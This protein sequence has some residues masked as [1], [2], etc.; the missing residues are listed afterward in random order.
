MLQLVLGLLTAQIRLAPAARKHRARRLGVEVLEGR[1]LLSAGQLDVA[2]DQTGMELTQLSFGSDQVHALAIEPNSQIVAV[3]QTGITQSMFALVRFNLDGTLDQSFGSGGKV[4]T[5]VEPGQ[6][7]YAQA[8]V[9][10]T[11]G[12]IV[13]AGF[14]GPAGNQQFALVRYNPDGSLDQ[15]FGTGG[16]V[17]TSFVSGGNAVAH[18]MALQPDGSLVVAG[19]FEPDPTQAASSFA[20]ARYTTSGSL[21]TSFGTGGL[22]TTSFGQYDAAA[23]TV[24]VQPDGS[25]VA[26]GHTSTSS[27]F[28]NF[29]L[30]RYHADGSLDP[31]FGTGGLVMTTFGQLDDA[32]GLVLQSDGK[33]VAAGSYQNGTK[34]DVALARYNPDGSLDPSFGS[35]GQVT[36][37]LGGMNQSA[38]AVVVQ[39]DGRLVAAGVYAPLGPSQFFLAR[40]N[41]DGSLDTTF[42]QAGLVLTNLSPSANSGANALALLSDGTLVA[43]GDGNNEF[44]LARYLDLQ[45]SQLSLS[46]P[47]AIFI[48]RAYQETLGR[49]V[50]ASGLASW[51]AALATGAT[52][53]QVVLGITASLEYRTRVVDGLY[54]SLL[55]RPADPFGETTFVT[56]L[57]AG[58]TVEQV[59]AAILGSPEYYRRAGSADAAFLTSLYHAVLSRDVDAS[60]SA[61]WMSALSNGMDRA[62][63][64]EQ[65]LTSREAE[66]DLVL[67]DY[68]HFLGRSADAAGLASWVGQLASGAPDELIQA[69]FLGSSEFYHRL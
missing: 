11:D 20:L 14:A 19:S 44:A 23:N 42:G 60:G 10:Q 67:P 56:A 31:S 49:P 68:E 58:L 29:A 51:T 25:I 59:K 38:G 3:G 9:I 57:G 8:A 43:G 2:F 16:I 1:V 30:A 6:N 21:D 17:L 32:R 52:R 12:K 33:L 18:S 37:D 53:A 27:S 66:T 36:T 65:V 54:A 40:Y 39:P 50:D 69:G 34:V 63:L 13:A 47:N 41:T 28:F 48:N 7:S 24:L 15:S 4:T 22:V 61:V 35:S 64:A 62:T 45:A 46:T 55:G 26:A 5:D